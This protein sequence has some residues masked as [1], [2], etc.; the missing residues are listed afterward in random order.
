MV[1]VLMGKFPAGTPTNKGSAWDRIDEFC[2]ECA[3]GLN[4]WMGGGRR[5][6]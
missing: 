6:S 3:D 1:T 5:R 4:F 2:G